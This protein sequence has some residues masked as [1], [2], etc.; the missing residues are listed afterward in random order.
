MTGTDEPVLVIAFNRPDHLAQLIDR[1]RR[2]QPGLVYVAIDGPRGDRPADADLVQ[3]TRDAVA[4]IDWPC[5]VHTLFQDRNL[6]CGV[7]VS[8]AIGWFLGQEERGI[9][10]ED[11]IL[12]RDSFFGFC[13]ELLDRYQDDDRV[14]AI[15]G[16][17]FVPPEAVTRPGP[18]RFSRVPHI[19]GWATWRRAWGL[20]DLDISDWRQQLPR[21]G[22]WEAVGR[23]P[24]A[25]V[26]WKTHFDL[27]A[28]GA[29]DTW[30]YQLVFA[31]FAHGALTAT[32]NVNLVDNVGF[33]V[34]ATHTPDQPGFLRHSEDIE[35]P[36]RD[37]PVAVDERAD[38]WSQRH[39]FGASVAGMSAMGLRY[40]RR[41][42]G[43]RK[44]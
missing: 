26:Y 37:M 15:S 42:L 10:L 28:R 27:M 34:D 2:T 40:V 18:Y 38:K 31:G 30:D 7:G 8:T 9:I 1:L 6:G 43:Q 36:T 24:S 3:R 41:S 12:P 19:W 29:V 39:V 17:N 22:L 21:R 32:S 25:Y 4:A 35:L 23:S 16:C 14:L 5:D 44:A 13:T 33:G 11:D 20:H